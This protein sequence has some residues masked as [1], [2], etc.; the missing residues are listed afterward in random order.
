[1]IANYTENGWEII[2][3]RSHGLLAGQLC[4]RWKTSQ[5]GKRWV[6]TLVASADHDDVFNEFERGPLIGESGGPLDFSMNSFDQIASQKLIDMAMAKG[7][8]IALLISRHIAFTHG[9]EAAAQ[10]FL[11]SL[12]AKKSEWLT[13]SGS[14]E[15]ELAAAYEILEF[16]DALSLIICKDGIPPEGR[17]L[18]ISSGPDGSMYTVN[19]KQDR[20]VIMPWPF[21]EKSFE[22]SY[23]RRIIPE[24]TFKDDDVLRTLLRDT[25]ADRK[26]I[27]LS[28]R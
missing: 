21:S 3:Q 18:E 16:C 20:M 24:L 6:E 17:K 12:T 26:V 19:L 11:K 1:M 5:R 10:D 13:S 23:E 27:I 2:A 8:F 25:L 15:E 9:K 22:V 14:S 7:S 28:Q 4:A